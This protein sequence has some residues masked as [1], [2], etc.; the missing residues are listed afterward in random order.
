MRISGMLGA[1]ELCKLCQQQET[2][3]KKGIKFRKQWESADGVGI[4]TA[5]GAVR[6]AQAAANTSALGPLG[7]G[8]RPR[9]QSLGLLQMGPC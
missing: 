9:S 5:H 2:D 4:H 6:S 7:Q 8:A 3:T 1:A